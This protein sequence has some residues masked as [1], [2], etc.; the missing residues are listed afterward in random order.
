MMLKF[1]FI[2]KTKNLRLQNILWDFPF[3]GTRLKSGYGSSA[4]TTWL[5][6]QTLLNSSGHILSSRKYTHWTGWCLGSFLV[7]WSISHACW[8][9]SYTEVSICSLKVHYL[10]GSCGLWRASCVGG[11]ELLAVLW[12]GVCVFVCTWLGESLHTG[13]FRFLLMSLSVFLER[14]FSGFYLRVIYLAAQ[15]GGV[16]WLVGYA[17]LHSTCCFSALHVS[18]VFCWDLGCISVQFI[19]EITL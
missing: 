18:H 6:G 8:E 16:D 17:D 4:A 19:Q 5:N 15:A 7:F 9:L 3:K 13:V 1:I 10:C 11:L 2:G 14:N 12:L